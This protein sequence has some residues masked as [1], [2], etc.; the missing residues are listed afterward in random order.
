MSFVVWQTENTR[1]QNI[2]FLQGS[3]INN[4]ILS[5]NEHV[6]RLK[7]ELFGTIKEIRTHVRIFP[8]L[9]EFQSFRVK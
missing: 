5:V 8:S 1:I 4:S 2:C 6:H 9:Q 7:K 3:E